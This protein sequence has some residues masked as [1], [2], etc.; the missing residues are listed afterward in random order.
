MIS[1]AATAQEIISS[2]FEDGTSQGWAPRGGGVVITPSTE[3]AYSGNWSL[4]VTGRTSNWHG[5]SLDMMAIL[6]AEAVYSISAYVKLVEGMPG[7][8]LSM[9]MQRTPVGDS[10]QYEWI[11][12]SYAENDWVL[13]EGTYMFSGDVAD[14]LVYIEAADATAEYYIDDFTINMISPPPGSSE[15]LV[16]NGFETGT[17]G[18]AP[19]GSGVVVQS[20]TEAAHSG[21]ASLKVT[22]RTSGW[23][24]A[25]LDLMALLVP[26]A[27]YE[28][29]AYVRLVDGQLPTN[30]NMTIQRTGTDTIT[31]Y[32]W[33]ASAGADTDWVILQ[34]SY[35][36]TDAANGLLV[37]IE[38]QDATT[39]YY[40][41][42]FS[43]LMTTPPPLDQSGIVTDFEDGTTQGWGSR[44]GVEIVEATSMDA[45]AGLYSLQT[46]GRQH[47]FGGPSINVL[48][49]MHKGSKYYISVWTKLLNGEPDTALKVS[50][51]RTSNGTTNYD[52]VVS[53]ILVTENNWVQL[54][55]SYTMAYDVDSLSLYVE[56]SSGLA[57]FYIDDF[58]LSYIEP[59]DIQTD[60]PP[61]KDVLADYFPIGAAI[62]PGATTTIHNELVKMH[63]S[64][65]TAENVMKP[66]SLQKEEGIFSFEEA[67]TIVNFAKEND[68][69]VRGHTLV[70]HEQTPAWFFQDAEGNDLEAT[71]E[72]RELMIQRL[73]SH[74]TT[75]VNHFKG[76]VYAWDVV[77]EAIDPAQ[78]DGLRR[79]K[80]YELI[81]PEYI[82]LAFQFARAADPDALLYINEYSTVVEVSKRNILFEI[83]SGMLDRGI[84]VDG[85]G[86][87]LH[88]DIKMPNAA[89]IGETI[90][91]FAGLGLDNHITELDMSIYPNSTDSYTT[92]P[93][94]IL[95]AQGYRYKEIFDELRRL[96]D[97]VSSVT[98]WGIAD[99][100]TWLS[101]HPIS[102][103]NL[104]L[105]FDEELQAK[106]AYWGIVDP[107][108]LP[109]LINQQAI[110]SGK[111]K[112]D[113]KTDLSWDIMPW[114]P[115]KPAGQRY[116]AFKAMWN[117]NRLFILAE[118]VDPVI[119]KNNDL[120]EVFLDPNNGKTEYY[121]E[122]DL[123]LTFTRGRS[124][125]NEIKWKTTEIDGGYRFEAEISLDMELE[126]GQEIG[127]DMRFTDAENPQDV[128]SWND[129]THNQDTDTSK[130]GTLILAKEISLANAARLPHRDIRIDGYVERTWDRAMAFETPIRVMGDDGATAEIRT[131]WSPDDKTLY[132]LAEVTD[133]LL[134]DVSDN[135]WEEDSIEV[136][137]DQ[138][139]GKT[140][141][142]EPDD[143]QYRVN[144]KNVQTFGGNAKADAIQ[145]AVCITN[146]GYIVELSITLDAAGIED[147]K[148]IGFDIQVNDDG[149]GNGVRSSVVT[150]NDPEGTAY[151]N[152]EN[153][154][155]L[156]LGHSCEKKHECDCWQKK[157]KHECDEKTGKRKKGCD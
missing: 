101:T 42:D 109:I 39:E 15:M 18:W 54:A 27:E 145:S 2:D 45:H 23:H 1:G 72:N 52:T 139:N 141:Y 24:G 62:E 34:G 107:T 8:N 11:A 91:L 95:I 10:T 111:A 98:M 110:P 149:A 128:L 83:V 108:T 58:E 78:P 135:P 84:P 32:E 35:S 123:A 51:Q 150:W 43:I 69:L 92:V 89:G 6:E 114:I 55:S 25:S 103:I 63:F 46:T 87:Q 134:S 70:W 61:L 118:V 68:I 80:W 31:Y 154:G 138:N 59:K 5:A 117:D 38:A 155:V 99:D 65:L 147:A 129:L 76:D 33:V 13:L 50:I 116:G 73:E 156:L 104:P 26:E 142:Y 48:G 151:K 12:S 74:I 119:N 88:T 125:Q 152:T 53:S 137:I 3:A 75:V 153:F 90:E 112:I 41:D 29:T 136:F 47:V 122:D 81:G 106:Y 22:G 86:H 146:E 97:N 20:V 113:G 127:F 16:E 37:Y 133:N 144:F 132:M 140:D 148:F 7:T 143:G 17:E 131:M 77:N 100:N 115:I 40:I 124:R 157:K 21:S 85:V 57:S 130:F 96:K 94:E 49:K 120:I 36:F 126:T 60:I 82:D 56:S 4:K 67:D 93:E 71:P 28:F 44:I 30:L 14:I 64:S 19:R 79:S 105:L 121:E 9:T 66:D 102:R